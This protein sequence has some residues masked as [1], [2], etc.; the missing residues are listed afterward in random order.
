M[1]EK[2]GESILTIEKLKEH[3][4]SAE[5]LTLYE[6]ICSAHNQNKVI[7]L[8]DAEVLVEEEHQRIRTEFNRVNAESRALAYRQYRYPYEGQLRQPIPDGEHLRRYVSRE[9]EYQP[10]GYE[11][12]RC[13]AILVFG[14]RCSKAVKQGYQEKQ[15]YCTKH[16]REDCKQP[17]GYCE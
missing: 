3:L 5:Y 13:H 12:E 1:D 15:K 2:I 4:N 11:Q 17:Y 8:M 10:D 9:W 7:N 6:T 14:H 16:F